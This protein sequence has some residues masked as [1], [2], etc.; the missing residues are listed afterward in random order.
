M[1]RCE[2]GTRTRNGG[3]WKRE[4]E[5]KAREGSLGTKWLNFAW[6]ICKVMGNRNV[7]GTGRNKEVFIRSFVCSNP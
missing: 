7:A 4:A 5:K 6:R 1:N 2:L 3:E